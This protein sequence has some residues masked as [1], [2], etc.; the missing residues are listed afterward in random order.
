METGDWEGFGQAQAE[1]QEILE[2]MSALAAG[3]PDATPAPMA[4]PDAQT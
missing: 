2:M 3:A 1:L 4:T